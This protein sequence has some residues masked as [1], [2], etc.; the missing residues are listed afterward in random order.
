MRIAN[1]KYNTEKKNAT[2]EKELRNL[3]YQNEVNSLNNK[4]KQLE[5]RYSAAMK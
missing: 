2:N 5:D 4:I 1:L 3:E